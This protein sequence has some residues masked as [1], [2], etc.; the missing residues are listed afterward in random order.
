MDPSAKGR[1]TPRLRAPERIR[2][3]V[4]RFL[5]RG[6]GHRLLL[7]LSI[8][9]VVALFAGM[10]V[11]LLDPE[12]SEVEEGIWWAFLRLSDPGYL[13]DDEGIARRTISTV[14]TVLG[15]VL[16]LGLLVAILTQWMNQYIAR[17]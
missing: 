13:G 2:F 16:F 8:V 4:E 17:L 3:A 7:A 14:V 15:Y 11:T 6:L 5:L 10:I 1:P 12:F 9:A